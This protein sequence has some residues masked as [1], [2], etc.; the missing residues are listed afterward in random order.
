MK[1]RRGSKI[2]VVIQFE[3]QHVIPCLPVCPS[4][5]GSPLPLLAAD[6]LPARIMGRRIGAQAFKTASGFLEGT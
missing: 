5:L 3:N 1:L 4:S 2:R 6:D